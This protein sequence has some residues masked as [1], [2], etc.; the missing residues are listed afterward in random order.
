MVAET[1][2]ESWN[3]LIENQKGQFIDEVID[4][5]IAEFLDREVVGLDR[6]GVKI[7]VAGFSL[8]AEALTQK[9][10]SIIVKMFHQAIERDK[11]DFVLRVIEEQKKE[12]ISESTNACS[13]DQDER[14][15]R[16]FNAA[17]S[18]ILA[19]KENRY[20]K[21]LDILSRAAVGVIYGVLS[22]R[23]ALLAK[24][25]TRIVQRNMPLD[26]AN[27]RELKRIANVVMI[28]LQSLLDDNQTQ[29][30]SLMVLIDAAFPLHGE[31]YEIACAEGD[32]R[33][34]SL[35]SK[36]QDGYSFQT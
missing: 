21:V 14:M 18:V 4:S 19:A 34:I 26:P 9:L 32:A 1:C 28:L 16:L 13:K 25:V 11:Q 30:N 27:E 12:F 23:G 5:R 33:I 31:L 36:Y 17:A 3:L 8:K 15:G 2:A 10:S 24:M 35:I 20:L 29:V 22:N 7:F 6:V